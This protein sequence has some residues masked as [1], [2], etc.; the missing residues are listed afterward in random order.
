MAKRP[1]DVEMVSVAAL[2]PWDRNPRRNEAAIPE[3]MRSIER[4]GFASPIVARREDRRIIAGHTRWVAAGRLGLSSVPVRWMDL[5][6]REASAL[7]LADNK[8][9]ELAEWDDDAL[10]KL[11]RDLAADHVD[12]SGLGWSTSALDDLVAVAPVPGEAGDGRHVEFDARPG[13]FGQVGVDPAK[14]TCPK[15][16]FGFN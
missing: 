4:F 13:E 11:L 16:G 1:V 8:L 9:G 6:E 12:L 2:V 15:C 3:V 10:A 14:Y 5:S 7:A